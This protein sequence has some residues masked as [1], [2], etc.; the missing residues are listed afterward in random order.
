MDGALV[1]FVDVTSIVQAEQHQRLMVDE[2]NHRVR[3]MLT[4]VISLATQT[5]RQSK[6]LP[7][8]S[9]SLHGPGERA[10]R[11]LHAVEPGQLDRGAVARCVAGGAA[12]VHVTQAG[13]MS[14]CP[15]TPVRLKP[16]GALAM[17]MA[18]HELVTNAVKY[19]A[20]SVPE[21][22][23]AIHWDIEPARVPASDWSGPGANRMAR[24]SSPPRSA[25]VRPVDDR[26]QPAARVE[27]RG[28]IRTSNPTG[29]RVN[30][31]ACRSIRRSP[32]APAAGRRGDD[33]IRLAGRRVLLVED[34]A[35]VAML[36]ETA[37]EDENC[38][39][40]GPLRPLP[41]AWQRRAPR[42]W[43]LRCSTSTWPATWCSRPRKSLAARGVPFL[44]L[45]GY[46][47]VAL[48]SDRRHWPICAKPFSLQRPG[49]AVERTALGLNLSSS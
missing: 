45:S 42:R 36:V 19:G 28:R 38:I 27:G 8:F 4:V 24:R 3:N 33:R 44:L 10:G 41:E 16:R 40:V 9:D 12:A 13:T 43:I 5:L 25:G 23:V 39:I 46:G 14:A 20:L 11:R 35:L 31:D 29:L 2:L 7:E 17:G 26:T 6:S 22:K 48:P 34:E 1:T 32:A 15:A 47:E 37:L 21:G 49:I 18:V 30:A